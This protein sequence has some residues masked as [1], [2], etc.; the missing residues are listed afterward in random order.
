V[1]QLLRWVDGKVL[2]KRNEGKLA[3]QHGIGGNNNEETENNEK[4]QPP[5]LFVVILPQ[6]EAT[7]PAGSGEGSE[8]T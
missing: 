2:V 5:F 4:G 7:V 1:Q 6:I 8:E 3:R